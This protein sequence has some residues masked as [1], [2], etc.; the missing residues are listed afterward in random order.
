MGLI[1]GSSSPPFAPGKTTAHLFLLACQNSP[2]SVSIFSSLA[3]EGWSRITPS[4]RDGVGVAACRP[5]EPAAMAMLW[6]MFAPALT[7]AKNTRPRSPWSDSHG[8]APDAAQLSAAQAS[9]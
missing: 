5:P 6:V 1:L 4:I 9:S 7:P 8:S 2:A 3:N